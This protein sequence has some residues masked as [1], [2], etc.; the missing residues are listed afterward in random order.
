MTSVSPNRGPGPLNPIHD[1][2]ETSVIIGYC[3]PLHSKFGLWSLAVTAIGSVLKLLFVFQ[4]STVAKVAQGLPPYSGP[5]K[6]KKIVGWG[7]GS[8]LISCHMV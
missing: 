7:I 6:T 5:T 2:E 1:N 3:H 4:I 8:L